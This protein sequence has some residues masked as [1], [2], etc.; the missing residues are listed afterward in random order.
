MAGRTHLGHVQFLVQRIARGIVLLF[1]P[2]KGGLAA[3]STILKEY[4]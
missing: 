1:E 3:T 4:D 2:V